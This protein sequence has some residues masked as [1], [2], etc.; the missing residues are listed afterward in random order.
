MADG[1]F[2]AAGRTDQSDGA[3]LPHGKTQ[4]RKHGILSVFSAFIGKTHVVEHDISAHEGNFFGMIGV[5]FFRYRHHFA[6]AG[7]PRKPVRDLLEQGDQR[8][9]GRQK[10]G[11]I[12]NEG[13]IIPRAD[14]AEIKEQT[15]RDK[16]DQI[17][18]VVEKSHAA[19]KHAHIAVRL[20]TGLFE[21][22]V[23]TVELFFLPAFGRVRFGNADAR[24]GGLD[25][26]V[27][28]RDLLAGG[29]ERAVHAAAHSDR[30]EHH[31]GHEQNDDERQ[32][33]IDKAEHDHRSDDADQRH[34]GI[35]R[36]V[37]REFGSFEKVVDDARHDGA[38][39]R[40]VEIGKRQPLD[41]AEKLFA[42]I[43][44]NANAQNVPPES[45]DVGKDG[46]EH[47][48]RQKRDRP[49][50]DQFDRPVG[51][52]IVHDHAGDEGIEKIAHRD[53]ERTDKIEREQFFMRF[54]IGKKRADRALFFLLGILPHLLQTSVAYPIYCNIFAEKM[55]E[56]KAGI[57]CFA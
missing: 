5:R 9:D 55:P 6:E 47:V 21:F 14:P 27:H 17:Q 44:L 51:N 32:P 10:H 30:K 29:A 57:L 50:D 23:G 46:F 28:L 48:N 45:D 7:K 52:E 8:A 37:M 53:G 26:R 11:D 56:M 36:S 15:A 24:N 49:D 33:R 31:A 1:R 35:L 20:G 18:K 43:R 34:E 41:V 40:L 42:H 4:M 19:L 25:A 16:R 22:A 39:L 12:Q 2:S 3:S 38:R 54:I 13:G